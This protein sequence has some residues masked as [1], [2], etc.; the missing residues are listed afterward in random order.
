MTY[1]TKRTLTTSPILWVDRETLENSA[2]P[3][4]LSSQDSP[5]Q[6]SPPQASPLNS[7]NVEGNDIDS[8]R[9][10]DGSSFKEES[11]ST[12]SEISYQRS[13]NPFVPKFEWPGISPTDGSSNDN[14]ADIVNKLN[15]DRSILKYFKLKK[16]AI[17][18]FFD[19]SPNNT[20]QN[21]EEKNKRLQE[22]DHDRLTSRAL[23]EI[24]Q[25]RLQNNGG[26]TNVFRQDSSD[27]M[28]ED[29]FPD[30]ND[31]D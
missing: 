7:G 2:S 24:K 28:P 13:E 19:S 17:K 30:Y 16:E 14:V 20:S 21:E 25:A 23:L 12:D 27:I 11:I 4:D 10:T 22:L 3:Q 6:A 5:S 1:I 18:R 9:S 8:V 29:F 15:N 26:N 31:V